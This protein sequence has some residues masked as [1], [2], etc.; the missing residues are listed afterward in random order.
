VRRLAGRVTN[1]SI[2]CAL[3][4]PYFDAT[5]ES[6]FWSLAS[7]SLLAWIF[8]LFAIKFLARRRTPRLET[9]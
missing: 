8:S 5:V 9:S 2:L 7:S 6:M 1:A 4:V 3:I